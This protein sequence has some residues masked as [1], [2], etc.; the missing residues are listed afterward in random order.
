MKQIKVGLCAFGMSGKVFHA[1]FI[2]EH[3]GFSLTAV[4]KRNREESKEK[5]PDAVIYRSV[6][7]M[8][9]NADVDL[10]VVNTPVQ[11]HFDY[12]KASLEAGKNVIVEKPFTV[13]TAEAEEL[14]RLAA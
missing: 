11:T 7:E 2:K 3:P 9:E 12:V 10:V 6:E 14:V 4:V 8:L 1:P 5:Y 13:G